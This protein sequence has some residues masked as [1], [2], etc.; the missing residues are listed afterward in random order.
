MYLRGNLRLVERC[1][2]FRFTYSRVFEIQFVGI[3]QLIV[4]DLNRK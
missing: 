3:E 2:L 1:Y 4:E